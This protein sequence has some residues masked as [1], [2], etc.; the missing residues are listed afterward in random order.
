MTLYVI[1]KLPSDNRAREKLKMKA[2]IEAG[3]KR[4]G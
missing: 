2:F 1:M 3:N 4:L